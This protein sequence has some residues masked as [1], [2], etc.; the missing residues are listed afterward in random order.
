MIANSTIVEETYSI[1]NYKFDRMYSKKAFI[2]WFTGEGMEQGEFN[3][4]RE[5]LE[6]LVKDYEEIGIETAEGE[7][8]EEGME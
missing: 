6:A 5:D 8:E 7:G 4:A 1:T 2:H 3:E